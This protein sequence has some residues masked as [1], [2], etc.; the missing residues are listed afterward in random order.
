MLDGAELG[1]ALAAHRGDTEAALAAYEQKLFPR[2]ETAAAESAV[3]LDL[4][5]R[6]DTPQGL[7][8]M[9]AAHDSAN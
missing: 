6:A 2:S 1:Q 5:F 4:C 8:N 9:F 7:L 3:G